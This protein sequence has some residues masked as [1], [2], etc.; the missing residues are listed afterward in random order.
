MKGSEIIFTFAFVIF[1]IVEKFHKSTYPSQN[2]PS[3]TPIPDHLVSQSS[4]VLGVTLGR[5]SGAVSTLCNFP[6]YAVS[7][8]E[9]MLKS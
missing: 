4:L 6:G 3:S 8:G 7:L 5:A 9:L 1:G 2:P